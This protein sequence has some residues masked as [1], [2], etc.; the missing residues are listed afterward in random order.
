MGI[1]CILTSEYPEGFVNCDDC[2]ETHCGEPGCHSD[3]KCWECL[4][5]YVIRYVLHQD[6]ST[7]SDHPYPIYETSI[8]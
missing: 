7:C 4:D 6:G 5:D 2:C 3:H 8:S 1:I